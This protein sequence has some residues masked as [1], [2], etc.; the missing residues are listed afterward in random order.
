VWIR[1]LQLE[2]S[3][4]SMHTTRE[5]ALDALWEALSIAAGREDIPMA[6]Q[7]KAAEVERCID[8]IIAAAPEDTP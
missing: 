4:M 1:L 6:A 7:L 5:K 3:E 2:E 8:S